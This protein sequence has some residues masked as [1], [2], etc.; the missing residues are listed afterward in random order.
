[1][2]SERNGDGGKARAAE[3]GNGG[4][5]G[6]PMEMPEIRHTKLFINGRF[7]DAV[8]GK[9]FETRDPRTGEVI[10][11]LAEGDKADIDLAVK[12]AREAFD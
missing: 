2:A 1:M 12:A 11:K 3:T 4:G 5:S 9:T 8:S 10:A 7:V 6:V